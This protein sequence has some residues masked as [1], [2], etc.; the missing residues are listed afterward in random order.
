MEGAL[1]KVKTF[2]LNNTSILI[3][4]AVVIAVLICIFIAYKSKLLESFTGG[5]EYKPNSG[6]SSDMQSV[7]LMMFSVDWCP[8]CKS[9]APEWEK[10]ENEFGNSQ[11][12]GKKVIFT[13]MNCTEETPEIEKLLKKYTIEGYPT[14]K[15]L[16]DGEIINFEAKPTYPNLLQ[17]LKST[18]Q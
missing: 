12:N 18:I 13:K 16:K 17:F 11:I 6:S 15:L 3:S 7:E 1:N 8:H 2:A 14:I 9:A 5:N 10:L 4:V